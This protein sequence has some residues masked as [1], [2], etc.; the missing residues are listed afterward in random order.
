MHSRPF[1]DNCGYEKG[2]LDW[3]PG[4]QAPLKRFQ[5]AVG[6]LEPGRPIRELEWPLRRGGSGS[7]AARLHLGVRVI[8]GVEVRQWRDG[9]SERDRR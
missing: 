5:P 9:G 8:A 6:V 7:K 4:Q 2:K 1:A 3:K